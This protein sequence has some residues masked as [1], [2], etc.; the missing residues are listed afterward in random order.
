MT[1]RSPIRLG[2]GVW[3]LGFRGL[4]FR[5]WG[6]GF[7]VWGLGFTVSG[8]AA[9]RDETDSEDDFEIHTVFLGAWGRHERGVRSRGLRVCKVQGSCFRVY[10]VKGVGFRV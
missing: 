10:K 3:G 8:S 6:L 1:L 5:V 2:F 9:G 4:G 7:R